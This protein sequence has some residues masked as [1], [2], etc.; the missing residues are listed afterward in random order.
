MQLR[1][2]YLI[3]M[4]NFRCLIIVR[5]GIELANLF[6]ERCYKMNNTVKTTNFRYKFKVNLEKC[7]IRTQF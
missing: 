4:T 2:E 6:L 3:I 5:I 1:T 7:S